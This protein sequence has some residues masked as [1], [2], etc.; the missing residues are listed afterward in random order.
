MGA[1]ALVESV[2]GYAIGAKML[3]IAKIIT[4]KCEQSLKSNPKIQV[5]HPPEEVKK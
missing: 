4:Q 5:K 1:E 3:L 2:K